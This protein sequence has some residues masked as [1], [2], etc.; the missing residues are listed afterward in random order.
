MPDHAQY[1]SNTPPQTMSHEAP[2]ET[3]GRGARGVRLDC[4]Y[5]GES[6]PKAALIDGYCSR[7]CAA[8]HRGEKLL[9]SFKYD[10][11]LCFSCFRVL[12]DIDHPPE[13]AGPQGE[14]PEWDVDLA[15]DIDGPVIGIEHLTEHAARGER[16]D[17]DIPRRYQGCTICTC[18][19]QHQD[20]YLR[21]QDFRETVKRLVRVVRYTREE[22]QHDYHVDV[23]TLCRTLLASEHDSCEVALEGDAHGPACEA[24]ETPDWELALGRALEDPTE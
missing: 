22:G 1:P 5:C 3:G 20:S 9:R 12:K 8:A 10:H 11:R 7:D 13:N 14:P 21:E 19:S 16:I 24:C 17:T 4:P 18:G 23:R 2:A 6:T 15:R